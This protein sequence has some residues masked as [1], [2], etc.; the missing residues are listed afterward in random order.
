MINELTDDGK[1]DFTK[2][3]STRKKAMKKTIS[4][5]PN[6]KFYFTK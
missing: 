2:L 1:S 3:V 6:S 4:T 5:L